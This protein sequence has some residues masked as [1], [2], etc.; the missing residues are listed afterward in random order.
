MRSPSSH[1]FQMNNARLLAN[2]PLPLCQVPAE[3]A[4]GR[5]QRGGSG[6]F[7]GCGVVGVVRAHAAEP[8]MSQP[9]AP[10]VLC[11]PGTGTKGRKSYA[12]PTGACARLP[13]SRM[14]TLI[15]PRLTVV[16]P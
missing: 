12:T 1:R 15:Y 7:R 6:G 13:G 5:S 11:P 9:R 10:G 4:W 3:A 14:V 8:H 2:V 16:H